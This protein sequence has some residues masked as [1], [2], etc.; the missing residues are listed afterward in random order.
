[1]TSRSWYGVSIALTTPKS[2]SSIVAPPAQGGMRQAARPIIHRYHPE[3]RAVIKKCLEFA[4]FV[5][6][7]HATSGTIQSMH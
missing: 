4:I 2:R 1:M 7:Y 6:F 5:D 3:S